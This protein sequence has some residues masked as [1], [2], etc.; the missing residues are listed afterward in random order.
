MWKSWLDP[1]PS[2]QMVRA[3]LYISMYTSPPWTLAA[4]LQLKFPFK[5]AGG[6]DS[7]WDHSVAG[8]GA[9]SFSLYHFSEPKLH[10]RHYYDL[11]GEQ[12]MHWMLGNNTPY[13]HFGSGNSGGDISFCSPCHSSNL[14]QALAGLLHGVSPELTAAICPCGWTPIHCNM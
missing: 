5:S 4:I 10:T 8:A 1:G 6:A 12:H 7:I 14:N 3:R 11:L 2:I 13:H 9:A